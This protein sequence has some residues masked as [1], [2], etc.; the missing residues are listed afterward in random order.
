LAVKGATKAIESVRGSERTIPSIMGE[1]MLQ[2]AIISKG[3]GV[4]LRRL[5]GTCLNLI[6]IRFSMGTG[7]GVKGGTTLISGEMDIVTREG[8][9]LLKV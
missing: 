8:L 2:E 1:V 9:A 3:A 7:I 6:E 5:I 4:V